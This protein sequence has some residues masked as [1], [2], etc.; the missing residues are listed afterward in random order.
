MV[1]YLLKPKKGSIKKK[2]RL[3]RGIGS[4]RGRTCGRGHKGQKSR[5]GYSKKIGFEGGQ[6][7]LYK[8]I[9]KFVF[10]KNKKNKFF[11]L[12]LN[13]IQKIIDKN[14]IKNKIIDKKLLILLKFI[15]K[16]KKIK[17]LSNGKLKDKIIIYADKFSKNAYKKI[18]SN[19]SKINI[20]NNININKKFKKKNG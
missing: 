18:I 5:S 14:K 20:I 1:L 4:G 16:K 15:D 2:K 12:N 17:I 6:T 7:P 3:G 19:G 9:P 11:I 10:K 8:R 13:T